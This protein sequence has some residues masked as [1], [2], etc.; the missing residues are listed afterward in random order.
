M[1]TG[2]IS[3][4]GVVQNIQ[5]Y[6]SSSFKSKSVSMTLNTPL[7]FLDQT[8]LGDSIAI[9]GVCVT[10][11]KFDDSSFVADLSE[12]T[13]SRTNL[14][15]VKTQ[16]IINLEH[17]LSFGDSID[18][19]LVQGHVD[20]LV[21]LDSIG[22]GVENQNYKNIVFQLQNPNLIKYIAEKGSVCLN[23][24]SLTVN[25]VCLES[26]KFKVT[27]IPHTLENTNLKYLNVGDKLNIEIDMFARYCV[28]FLE[29]REKT[30]MAFKTK[31]AWE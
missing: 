15:L 7:G 21:V 1:F 2:I 10:V 25:D 29:N 27:I 16:D 6:S 22:T 18:G 28:N 17:A 5:D 23:G 3:A 31:E 4:L 26:S 20:G 11:V 8:K 13:L 30:K 14:S 12:E 24:I 9:N 19:H